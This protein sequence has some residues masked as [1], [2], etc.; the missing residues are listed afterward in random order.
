MYTSDENETPIQL[1]FE[2]QKTEALQYMLNHPYIKDKLTQYES[3]E[4]FATDN[5]GYAQEIKKARKNSPI[6]IKPV[7]GF[8]INK[9]NGVY[10]SKH[11]LAD[12][13]ID[14]NKGV[15][16]RSVIDRL[17]LNPQAES[18]TDELIQVKALLAGLG[19]VGIYATCRVYDS[20]KEDAFWSLGDEAACVQMIRTLASLG[21]KKIHVQLT[22]P[23]DSGWKTRQAHTP[24]KQ[25]K[26]DRKQRVALSK[27]TYLLPE[28]NSNKGTPQEINVLG[29]KV[30]ISCCDDDKIK[31]TPIT[32]SFLGITE[33]F[34]H[35]NRLDDDTVATVR[36]F[37]FKSNAQ[38]I[39][40]DI[41]GEKCNIV[42]VDAPP[43]SII[44][45]QA[46]KEIGDAIKP[47]SNDSEKKTVLDSVGQ[48]CGYISRKQIHA[49]VV[50]GL[51]H[52][53]CSQQ[54]CRL[55]NWFYAIKAVVRKP[56]DN[57]PIMVVISTTDSR[58]SEGLKIKAKDMDAITV[59]LNNETGREQLNQLKPGDIVLCFI[60]SL[61]KDIFEYELVSE[62]NLP[63]L[64]EGANLTSFLLENGY[65]YLSL[66]PRGHTPIALDMGYPLEAL[67]AQASSYKLAISKEGKVANTLNTLLEL[68]KENKYSDALSFIEKLSKASTRQEHEALEFLWHIPKQWHPQLETVTIKS[69]LKKGEKLGAIE[70]DALLSAIAPPDEA[71]VDYVGSCLNE[72]SPTVDHF[73]LQKMHVSQWNTVVQTLLAFG[74]H[75]GLLP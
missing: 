1:A 22:P 7:K 61:P 75:K 6:P 11:S 60:P 10:E 31:D 74:R 14:G 43:N 5:Y 56:T 71:L 41:A 15:K 67:K 30:V 72:N 16:Q 63:T 21:A 48:L 44:P 12:A 27:L 3:A 64:S 37:R 28:F 17:N 58:E 29:C 18:A 62:S 33:K 73:K 26:Y 32:L 49:S 46:I 9:F 13:L 47:Q 19:S 4:L 38:R 25:K 2:H 52:L 69:L 20:E 65:P 24:N 50:Y 51:K 23:D 34:R 35:C 53:T 42:S 39:Y 36:A 54:V 70:K 55:E 59:D 57:R 68:V 45:D 40:S 8:D 66:V